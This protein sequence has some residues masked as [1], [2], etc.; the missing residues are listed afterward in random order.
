[1][2]KGFTIGCWVIL[3][4]IIS[5]AGGFAQTTDLLSPEA[6][7]RIVLE[8]PSITATESVYSAEGPVLLLSGNKRIRASELTFDAASGKVVARDAAL[9]TCTHD[10][11]H[12]ALEAGK[13]SLTK[14]GWAEGHRLSIRLGKTKILYL[15]WIKLH[16][17]QKGG[18][19][20]MFPAVW[21]DS[22]DGISLSKNFV[23]YDTPRLVSKINAKV[24]T[25]SSVQGLATFNYGVGGELSDTIGRDMGYSYWQ[26]GSVLSFR[27]AVESPAEDKLPVV[28]NPSA[29][30]RLYSEYAIRQR[31]EDVG[32]PSTLV[33]KRPELGLRYIFPSLDSF[34]KSHDR[35][36]SL[37]PAADISWGRFREEPSSAG[38][39]DRLRYSI[40]AAVNLLNLG[41]RTALQPVAEQVWYKYK[42]LPDFQALTYG[43]EFSRLYLN[44]SNSTLRYLT[45]TSKG[46]TVLEIDDI[47]VEREIQAAAT[48]RNSGHWLNLMSAYN[49]DNQ[50]IYDW[51]VGY[52]YS[53]DCLEVGM[54]YNKRLE[55]IGFNLALKNL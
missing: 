32:N 13:L 14:T 29:R 28:T 36:L 9:T 1:M 42:H 37:S 17:S 16:F 3:L 46:S 19:K 41:P 26:P 8:A 35:R 15:P 24:T 31:V 10:P 6:P 27:D 23:I 4:W 44:G 48:I 22:S 2:I 33:F 40:S 18:S 49:C 5:A 54:Y 43:M 53:T 39:I 51:E 30:L 11:P 50:S 34:G 45:R 21:Y 38:T 47:D 52:G 12:Y 55:R 7:E 20:A 25:K